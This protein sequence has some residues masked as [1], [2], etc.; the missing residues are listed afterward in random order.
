MAAA[1]ITWQWT[2]FDGLS[3]HDLYDALR[4]RAEVFVVEQTCPYLDVDGVDL[5]SWHLLGR[6]AQPL[7]ALPAGQLVA[8]L[9]AVDPGVKYPEPSLGR[10]VNDPR[11]RGQGLGRLLVGE[12]LRQADAVWP[13][14]GNRISAQAH[15]AA[16]YGEFGFQPVSETYLED[17]IP[18]LEMWRPA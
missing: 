18:H 11:L 6:L 8:Y 13:G 14:Q 17:D 16:F 3:L 4:L 1:M 15:L 9:R 2:R 12:A 7:G 5:Q 10:V